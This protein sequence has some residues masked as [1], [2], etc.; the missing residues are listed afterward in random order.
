MRR[1]SRA[2]FEV[3]SR[4]SG[5]AVSLRRGGFAPLETCPHCLAL[6]LDEGAQDPVAI[7]TAA[8]MRLRRWRMGTNGA[9]GHAGF[10]QVRAITRARDALLRRI[11]PC[12]TAD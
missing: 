8:Q 11:D 10:D 5:G 9:P 4:R 7:I 1:T 6:G 2:R 12:G 3:V